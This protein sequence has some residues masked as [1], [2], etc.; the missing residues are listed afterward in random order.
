MSPLPEFHR[1]SL[2]QTARRSGACPALPA[3]RHVPCM[4]LLGQRKGLNLWACTL[5]RR[6]QPYDYVHGR[7]ELVGSTW[8]HGQGGG[9]W[10]LVCGR[11]RE[12]K[13]H[14][15]TPREKG[16]ALCPAGASHLHAPPTWLTYAT[17][18]IRHERKT[19]NRLQ[20]WQM[21]A[22]PS[23][24]ADSQPASCTVPPA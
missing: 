5:L 9:G 3:V 12:G 16:V 17:C 19:N 10:H 20:H 7:G 18:L 8:M 24:P 21:A 14:R 2:S 23:R 15:G 1:V 4:A 22:V 6:G 13:G 11:R